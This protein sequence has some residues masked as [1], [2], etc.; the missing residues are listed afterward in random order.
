MTI[1][2]N[3]PDG[4]TTRAPHCNSQRLAIVIFQC[5]DATASY[6]ASARNSTSNQPATRRQNQ[7]DPVTNF[8][9]PAQLPAKESTSAKDSASL[10]ELRAGTSHGT[11]E[12]EPDPALAMEHEHHCWHQREALNNGARFQHNL[13]GTIP[14]ATSAEQS[15]IKGTKE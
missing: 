7:P 14:P 1:T 6:T 12:Q 3:A 15:P 9:L 8:K 2:V 11:Y 4:A 5:T 13:S 10:P